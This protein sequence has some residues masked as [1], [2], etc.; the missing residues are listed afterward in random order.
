[1]ALNSLVHD[2]SKEQDA[3]VFKGLRRTVSELYV[4]E[5]KSEIQKSHRCNITRTYLTSVYIC[6][7]LAEKKP[8]V[9]ILET[10]NL[11]SDPDN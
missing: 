2:I 9:P 3:F 8:L 10:S 5:P 1:M 7:C 4:D 11:R 6:F